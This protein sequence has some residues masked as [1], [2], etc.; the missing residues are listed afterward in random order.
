MRM[1][2]APL[3]GFAVLLI[4]IAFQKPYLLVPI[5]TVTFGLLDLITRH[6]WTSNRV[7]EWTSVSVLLKFI[8]H[9][10]ALPGSSEWSLPSFFR[11]GGSCKPYW[12][13]W[14]TLSVREAEAELDP[15]ITS[16]SMDKL[17]S[18]TEDQAALHWACRRDTE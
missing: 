6:W 1:T 2:P 14:P 5:A 4:G 9:F 8:S 10:V 16:A 17:F 3:I 7:G 18:N 11:F 15:E 13:P 12:P